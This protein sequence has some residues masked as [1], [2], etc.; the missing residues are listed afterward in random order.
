MS[1]QE[2]PPQ[3]REL[4]DRVVGQDWSLEPLRGDA[5]TRIYWRVRRGDGTTAIASFYPESIREGLDR[6]LRAWESLGEST[7]LPRLL[8]WD[9]CGL[10]QE[11]V[12]DCTLTSVLRQNRERGIELYTDAVD[13]L[14][15]MQKASAAGRRINPPFD[16]ERFLAE[17]DMTGEWYVE[18]L[19]GGTYGAGL[20][21]AFAEL[22]EL[23]TA[24]PYLLTHRDYHG[25]NVHVVDG[26]LVVIDFQDL[27]EGPDTYDLASLLRD[28]GVARL[29]GRDTE[30][31]LVERWGERIGKGPVRRRY[32][33]TLL[34]RTLKTLGTFARQAVERGR[35][36]YLEYVPPALE[37]VEICLGELGGWDTLASDLPRMW[38]GRT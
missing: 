19:A 16:R 33:E 22:A 2:V 26:R 30:L 12:G 13:L 6:A 27:R 7:P 29:L 31:S 14:A 15:E 32:H 28:R 3:T 37:T 25:E 9:T 5:S 35:E 4:L 8:G 1:D 34:Q 10:V 36:H 23:L 24:H 11:D 21:K 20:R 17:L 18:R 38:T